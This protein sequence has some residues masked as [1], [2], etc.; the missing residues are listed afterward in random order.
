MATARL[1]TAEVATGPTYQPVAEGA[2]VAVDTTELKVLR[3]RKTVFTSYGSFQFVGLAVART[4]P[5][6]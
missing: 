4:Y 2:H 1:I 5:G 3:S 6:S